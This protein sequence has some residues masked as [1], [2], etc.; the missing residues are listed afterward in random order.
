MALGF[1]ILPPLL[2]LLLV[3]I[4]KN[5][6]ASLDRSSF[7]AGFIFGTSSSAYQYEGG[8]RDG[9]RG[10]SIWDAFTHKHPE[11]ILDRS[12]GDVAVDSFHR[13]KEDVDIM[14][15]IGMDAYRFSISWS[16]ILPNGSLSGGIDKEGIRYYSKLINELI[17]NGV[18][19]FV[20][21][22]HFDPP[23]ALEEKYGGFLSHHIVRDFKIYAEIC[24]REFGNQVKNWITVNEPL[25]FCAKGYGDGTKA[26]GRCSPWKEGKCDFG[27]SGMEPYMAGHHMLLAHAAAVRL[28]KDEYQATQNGKIGISLN[29]RWFVPLSDSESDKDAANRALDFM[30]GWFMDPLTRGDYPL[31]MRTLV[32][33]RLPKFTKQQSR[34]LN[35]SFD[36]IGVNYYTAR[37]VSELPVSENV[38]ASYDTDMQAQATEMRNGIQI[39]PKA[40]SDWLYIYPRGI[41]DLL[42]HLKTKY[43]NPIIYITE[44]GVD[45][46][47]NKSVSLGEA[48]KDDTRINFHS[49]HLLNVLRAIRKG[50]NVRGY[51]A[52][53]LLDN[54]EWEDGYTVRFGIV[55]VDFENGLKRY[56]KSS[57]QWFSKI[58]KG[59]IHQSAKIH[60]L[61]M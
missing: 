31:S 43:D 47:N 9:G 61:V 26:P 33:N 7:P 19:P 30:L 60:S 59:K 11:K 1:G 41:G 28:Y 25:T 23:Q 20:T 5:A 49:K 29:S 10:P 51:F 27:D 22:L 44:N 3:A 53:S 56:P 35:G 58:L 18:Q 46:F 57:A 12:N 48:L 54:F 38:S 16:R 52:W 2:L 40:A 14:R 24:F 42:L 15:D 37:Y 39:G 13:Y 32:G 4:L 34:M 36:F 45:E 17:S 50:A 8:A 55:F 6:S 21:L